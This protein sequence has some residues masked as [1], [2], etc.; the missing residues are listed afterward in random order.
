MDISRDQSDYLEDDSFVRDDNVEMNL[1]DNCLE[2]DLNGIAWREIEKYRERRQLESILK[3]DLYD[4]VD[5]NSI[6]D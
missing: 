5:I 2:Y 3:D 4:G 6:W 1:D